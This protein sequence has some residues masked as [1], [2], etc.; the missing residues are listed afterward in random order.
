MKIYEI[1]KNTISTLAKS[2]CKYFAALEQTLNQGKSEEKA[3][4]KKKISWFL[5]GLYSEEV[6]I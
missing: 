4:T 6:R 1:P 2:K 3:I 5:D